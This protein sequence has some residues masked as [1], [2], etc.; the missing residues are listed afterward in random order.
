MIISEETKKLLESVNDFSGNHIKNPYEV[1]V[2]IELSSASGDMKKFEDLIFTSKY[3]SGL[4]TILGNNKVTGNE[5]MEKIFEEFKAQLLKVIELLKINLIDSESKIQKFF[6]ER[7]FGMNQENI[8][9]IVI[10][11]EDLSLCKEYF[12]ANPEV[13]PSMHL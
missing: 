13:L 2:L 3:I 4:K 9:N 10:L 5:Y 1:S 8:S 6:S 7:Y 11:T 12:N